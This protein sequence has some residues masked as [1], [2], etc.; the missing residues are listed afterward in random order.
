VDGENF[1]LGVV[2]VSSVEQ[3]K[4]RLSVASF[5]TDAGGVR[6]RRLRRR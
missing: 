5:A 3:K 1:P 2:R 6:R 4:G